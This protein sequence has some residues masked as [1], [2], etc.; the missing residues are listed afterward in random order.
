MGIEGS[1]YVTEK[2]CTFFIVMEIVVFLARNDLQ[3]QDSKAKDIGLFREYPSHRVLRRHI[4]ATF[5]WNLTT[6]SP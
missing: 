4:A 3:Y 6:I 2:A 1:T 5:H